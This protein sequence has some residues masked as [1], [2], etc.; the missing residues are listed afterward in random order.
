[1]KNTAKSTR[2]S[3]TTIPSVAVMTPPSRTPRPW[4]WSRFNPCT[5]AFKP[6]TEEG[7][8]P[9]WIPFFYATLVDRTGV[10]VQRPDG[11]S[12]LGGNAFVEG[13]VADLIRPQ[14]HAVRDVLAVPGLGN[15]GRSIGILACLPEAERDAGLV[16]G[17]GQAVPDEPGLVPELAQHPVLS[18]VGELLE[19]ALLDLIRSDANVLH[20]CS[21]LLVCPCPTR[22]NVSEI[23]ADTLG[24][25]AF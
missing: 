20:A 8:P 23:R 11:R 5:E 3:R 15:T 17:V 18:D 19:R 4:R 14:L 24:H 1:M 2:P 25:Q 7:D 22:A 12:D 10:R 16:T 9:R 21:P 13:E 6:S